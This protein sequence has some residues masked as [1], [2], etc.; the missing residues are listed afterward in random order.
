MSHPNQPGSG[1]ANG[2]NPPGT[3][4]PG[5]E[6]DPNA[7]A[8]D[9]TL[10]ILSH[11]SP[12]IALIV[13]VG[14]LSFLGPLIMWLVFRDRSTLVRNAAATAFNFHITLW[15]AIIVGWIFF[16]TIVGIPVAIIL[17]VGVG[18]LQLIFSIIGAVKASK[19]EVY[20]YPLQVPVLK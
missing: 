14:W 12:I 15:A 16:I 17:W 1:P 7:N 19:G 9:R 8:N 2:A 20:R 11:L 10:A 13:S 6:Y 3:A 18:L 5:R 4:G